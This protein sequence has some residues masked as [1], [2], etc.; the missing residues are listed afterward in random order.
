MYTNKLTLILLIHLLFLS[1][2]FSQIVINEVMTSNA[3]SIYDEDES[4]PDWIEIFNNSSNQIDL[5]GYYLSDS[6]NNLQRWIIPSYIIDAN[7]HLLIFASGKDQYIDGPY[8]NTVIKWVDV[9]KYR[10]RLAAPPPDDWKKLDFD[11]S[12]WEMGSTS[13]GY[14]DDDDSTV[15]S[16]CNTLYLRKKFAIDDINSLNSILLHIDYDDAFIAYL[17]GVEVA[18][19]NIGKFREDTPYNAFADKHH[20]AKIYQGGQPELCTTDLSGTLILNG[21]NLFAI[22]VFPAEVGD[23]D[24]TIIPYLTLGL[25]DPPLSPGGINEQIADL[26]PLMHTNFKLSDNE[27]L[28]LSNNLGEIID[29][30]ILPI[31]E[32]DASFGRYPDGASSWQY[33]TNPTPGQVNDQPGFSEIASEPEIQPSGN[34]FNNSV[35]VQ[36]SNTDQS[37]IYYSLDGSI[38]SDTSF[39]YSKPFTLDSTRVVKCISIHESKLQSK[40]S[41][42]TF[43]INEENNFPIV[44]LSTNPANLWDI[45]SGIYVKGN[46]Y[47]PEAPNYGANF[48]Q[49]WEREAHIEFFN[50]VGNIGFSLP[51]GIKIFGNITRCFPQKSLSI[52][53]RGQY[54]F[55]E[56]SYELFS[57]S[58]IKKF[59][60]LVLRNSGSDWTSTMLRD[61][62]MISLIGEL[63]LEL[64]NYC[65]AILFINGRYWGIHNIR[66]KINEDFIASRR[67]VS[68]NKIDLLENKYK[69]V[70]G[71]NDDY[72]DILYILEN[73]NFSENEFYN[74]FK[75]RIDIDNFFDYQISEIY[76]NNTDWPGSNVKFWREKTES[77]LWRWIIYDTDF[78]FGHLMSYKFNSLEFALA[79]NGPSWPNPP[80]STFLLRKLL[81]NQKYKYEF[82][83]R[84]GD[85]SNSL[86]KKDIVK[87]KLDL[88]KNRI[89]SQMPR[90]IK[91]WE[92]SFQY[93]D[94]I[95]TWRSINS[96]ENWENNVQVI[97]NFAENRL[98]YLRLYFID[99]FNLSGEAAINLNASN[100]NGG[101]VVI[102]KLVV[103]SFPWSG[104]YF[105][106]VPVKIKALPNYGYKFV[107]WS[108][109]IT[110][111]ESEMTIMLNETNLFT[112]VFEL[113]ED[114][115][116]V[117]INEINYNS[118]PDYDTEDWLEFYNNSS[119][120]IDLTNWYF[121][122]SIDSNKFY[123]PEGLVLDTAKY[124][125]VCR[126]TT[127][128]K[129][130]N[131]S[132]INLLDDFN[133]SF[134]NGGEQI[135]LY[136][137][138]S[139]L[140]DSVFYDDALPWPIE[141]DGK[142]PTLSLKNPELN[143]S[144]SESWAASGGHGTPGIKN[145]VYTDISTSIEEEKIV[146]E[147]K[148]LQNYPNPFNPSTTI[149]YSLPSDANVKVVIYDIMGRI[150]KTLTS[151]TQ[152]SG[153]HQ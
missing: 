44:S 146:T 152:T 1:T 96:F 41:V 55:N 130:F 94:N 151:E 110:S 77:P 85:L 131:P 49:D 19:R 43:F 22:E 27:T 102:N 51:C 39:L 48:W 10:R 115:P 66:D 14:G 16:P 21:E 86:F 73:N 2:S 56:L 108:G 93:V 87:M 35:T 109:D 89:I 70:E 98:S 34:F 68:A 12:G 60:A 103:D 141:P 148:L 47:N 52:F 81:E 149:S 64:Q 97:Y 124:L 117:V 25:K 147:Y 29:S 67:D 123:F 125:V 107:G 142:G 32:T 76:F 28:Y 46:N 79:E 20:E 121:T 135:K 38:P 50:E 99:Q 153:N 33:F 45:D 54:G 84:F 26:L 88:I 92:N 133:F 143:N 91:K 105:Q 11:D 37:K 118:A 137:N 75:T 58:N 101:T 127:A 90:H 62:F 83:N 111:A 80:W 31:I 36:L 134:S 119:N 139:Q 106:D 17:N 113:N 6:K 63:D 126:D 132:T 104:K 30:V 112:A 15:I 145:D 95:V 140:V 129:Q 18:R 53:F 136:N 24:I 65:P 120:P 78:G 61:P 8:W 7:E 72:L 13:I 3:N 100:K 69:V 128:F 57:N 74:Y 40:V 116:Q 5:T 59:D 71:T 150:I 9:W 144:N 23:D 122:D 138:L 82:I 114:E 4:T 42:R